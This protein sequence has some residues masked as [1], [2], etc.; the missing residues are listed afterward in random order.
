MASQI[1]LLPEVGSG[2]VARLAYLA[3]AAAA[4]AIGFT[5]WVTRR[6]IPG[7]SERPPLP[8]RIDL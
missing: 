5:W 7:H 3:I 6:Q 1:E 8:E 2:T 4:M